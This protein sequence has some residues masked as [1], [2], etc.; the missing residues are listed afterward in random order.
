VWLTVMMQCRYA[1]SWTLVVVEFIY[2]LRNIDQFWHFVCR[3][4]NIYSIC[5]S[6]LGTHRLCFLCFTIILSSV[7]IFLSELCANQTKV[8]MGKKARGVKN[9]SRSMNSV[10]EDPKMF[11]IW[12]EEIHLHCSQQRYFRSDNVWCGCCLQHSVIVIRDVASCC[13]A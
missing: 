2:E 8:K 7:V 6:V 3:C 11:T 10:V 12:R 4:Y 5:E 13:E 1:I 9:E